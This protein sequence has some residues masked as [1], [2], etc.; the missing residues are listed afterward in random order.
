MKLLL[1]GG[2][3]YRD[4]GEL[5]IPN[6]CYRT[7]RKPRTWGDKG[8]VTY[9]QCRIMLVFLAVAKIRGSGPPNLERCVALKLDQRCFSGVLGGH[10]PWSELVQA[11]TCLL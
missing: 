4:D 3:L 8:A 10:R 9:H 1:R 11:R 7:V 6:P 2:A 5:R